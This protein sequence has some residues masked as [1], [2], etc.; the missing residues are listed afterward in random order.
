LKAT[1]GQPVV[2]IYRLHNL[3]DVDILGYK[4]GFDIDISAVLGSAIVLATFFLKLEDFF[5]SLTFWR[6]W[7]LQLFWLLLPKYWEI[8]QI[9]WSQYIMFYR[10]F[11]KLIVILAIWSIESI[12]K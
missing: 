4:L 3:F 9:I 6:F 10:E 11:R 1:F 7:A 2:G 12:C 8:F 5:Q